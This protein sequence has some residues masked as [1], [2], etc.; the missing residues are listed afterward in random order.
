MRT[1]CAIKKVMKSKGGVANFKALSFEHQNSCYTHEITDISV[2]FANSYGPWAVL[3]MQKCLW[4]CNVPWGLDLKVTAIH[5]GEHRTWGNQESENT[6]FYVTCT[7]NLTSLFLQKFHVHLHSDTR[8]LKLCQPLPAWCVITTH[9]S[10][11]RMSRWL[12]LQ[13]G[14]SCPQDKPN[15]TVDR[16]DGCTSEVH[17]RSR[18]KFEFLLFSNS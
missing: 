14:S 18:F 2:F 12:H 13:N 6:C 1:F 11:A 4:C 15:P 10:W 16:N 7:V 3:G 8:P 9:H 17:A 5:I